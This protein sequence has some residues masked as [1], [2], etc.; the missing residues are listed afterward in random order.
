MARV[1]PTWVLRGMNRWLRDAVTMESTHAWIMDK[2]PFMK[3]RL[4]TATQDLL[5]LRQ[6]YATSGG[7]F[8]RT[9]RRV[10]LDTLTQQTIVNGFTWHIGIM[11]QVADTPTWLGAYE[12]EMATGDG[13]EARAVAL[14]DQ[15]VL[16][17]QGGGQI[18]DL[19]KIQRGGPLLRVWLTFYSYGNMVFNANSRE[20]GMLN[21]K[22][23]ASVITFLG[24]L[25]L[26]NLMPAVATVALAHAL[27]KAD[28][29]DDWDDWL[30]QTSGEV[31][32]SALNT[33]ILSREFQGV[34]TALLGG[35]D[36]VRGYAGPAGA[37]A[38]DLVYKFAQQAKQL[39]PDEAFMKATLNLAGVLF[40]F[41][42]AQVDR[43]IRGWSALVEG[44]TSNP[45]VLLVGPTP[46]SAKKQ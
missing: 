10:T 39:E 36:T 1:G 35:G 4:D 26:I 27:G 24:H 19:A 11:Q 41:P 40:H 5:D 21:A 31:L 17:S 2:S 32:A 9:V 34:A 16:D 13:V 22:S 12:K 43:T 38:I 8:D 25:S 3:G 23:P 45:G 46:A 44:E 42:A 14:A 30:W 18:K 37:R 28:P 6:A 15:A 7:W 20:L 33:M 29:D